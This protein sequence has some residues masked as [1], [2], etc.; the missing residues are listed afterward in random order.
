[1][2]GVVGWLENEVIKLSSASTGVWMKLA[3]WIR[4]CQYPYLR[5]AISDFGLAFIEHGLLLDSLLQR[6]KDYYTYS[7]ADLSTF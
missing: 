6:V 5:L 4:A 1:M 7:F 2:E 3:S